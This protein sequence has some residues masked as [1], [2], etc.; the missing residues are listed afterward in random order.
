MAGR[1]G[2]RFARRQKA[3]FTAP[4]LRI[5]S[6]EKGIHFRGMRFMPR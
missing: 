3:R 6:A 4:F 1:S 2:F 5:M